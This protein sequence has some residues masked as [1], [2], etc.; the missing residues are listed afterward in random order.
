MKQKLA[1]F[2]KQRA[3][4]QHPSGPKANKH[5]YSKS[6]GVKGEIHDRDKSSNW[7]KNRAIK[8][9][10]HS[11]KKIKPSTCTTMEMELLEDLIY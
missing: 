5:S 2:D 4:Y 11:Q 9:N 10:Y 1:R 8:N 6:K 7:S 3:V